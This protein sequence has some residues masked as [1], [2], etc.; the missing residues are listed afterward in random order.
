MHACNRKYIYIDGLFSFE[1][2]LA[3]STGQGRNHCKQL[4]KERRPTVL[5][6]LEAISSHDS[7]HIARSLEELEACIL[8]T[9]ATMLLSKNQRSH[10]GAYVHRAAQHVLTDQLQPLQVI[11]VCRQKKV[12]THHSLV[13]LIHYRHGVG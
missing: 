9:C 1:F 13:T 6:M 4:L 11:P 5:Q 12:L 3:S 7:L 10:R 2:L 8:E